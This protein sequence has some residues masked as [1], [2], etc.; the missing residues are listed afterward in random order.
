MFTTVNLEGM[1]FMYKAYQFRFY[2]K[3]LSA[4]VEDLKY[5]GAKLIEI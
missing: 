4:V 3:D 2:P 5:I 1:L